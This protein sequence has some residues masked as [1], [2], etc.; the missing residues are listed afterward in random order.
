MAGEEIVDDLQCLD[1][2]YDEPDLS[3]VHEAVSTFK[4][5]IVRLLNINI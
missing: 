1:I 3:V 2:K 5:S 4:T